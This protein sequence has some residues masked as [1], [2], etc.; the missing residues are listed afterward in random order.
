MKSFSQRLAR[1][2]ERGQLTKADLRRWFKRPYSTVE[3]W[4]DDDREPRGP[5]GNEARHRLVLLE[6]GIA[7][8]R[9]FPVPVELSATE[10][11]RHI[12]K[13]YHDISAAIPR[14]N[15]PRGRLQMRN[16]VQ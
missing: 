9:G 2:A 7:E 6:K 8:R 10:R 12:E 15:T 4:L 1:C 14:K 16:G 11:P 5:A 3:T 13:L